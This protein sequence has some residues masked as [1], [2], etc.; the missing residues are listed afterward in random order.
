MPPCRDLA[1]ASPGRP[2]LRRF[3][4]PPLLDPSTSRTAATVHSRSPP[5]RSLLVASRSP[6]TRAWPHSPPH[7]PALSRSASAPQRWAQRVLRYP[8]HRTLLSVQASG[9]LLAREPRPSHISQVRAPT[10]SIRR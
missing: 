10:L 4:E 6:R 3:L 1:S 2:R 9:Q 7:S 8:S 5:C